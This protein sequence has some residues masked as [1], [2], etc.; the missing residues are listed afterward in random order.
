MRS[1]RVNGWEGN[2]L[3]RQSSQIGA[4]WSSLPYTNGTHIFTLYITPDTLNPS[5]Y[6]GHYNAFPLR[7]LAS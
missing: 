6:D 7:C 5:S 4:Y 2:G 1:G 3:L